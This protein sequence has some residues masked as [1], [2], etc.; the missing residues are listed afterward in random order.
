MPLTVDR[1]SVID[2]T[3]ATIRKGILGGEWK[4][5]LPGERRLSRDLSVGRNSVRVALKILESEGMVEILPKRGV[6]IMSNEARPARKRNLV[7]GMLSPSPM[8]IVY[9]RQILWID[10]LR[11]QLAKAGHILKYYSGHHYFRTG[12]DKAVQKL[13]EQES[14]DCW[15]LVAS[16]KA[17]QEWFWSNQIPCLIAG[18]CHQGIDLPFIDVDYQALSRHAVLTLRR[19]GHRNIVYLAP[20]PQLAGDI[21][22]ETGFLEGLEGVVGGN[23][24]E[25]TILNLENSVERTS[26]A[27]NRLMKQRNM[28]TALLINNPFQYLTVFSTLTEMGLQVPHDVSLICRGSEH[29]LSYL[30]PSPVRYEQNPIEFADRLFRSIRKLINNPSIKARSVLFMP[31]LVEGDS[32]SK[33][34]EQ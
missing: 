10:S 5:R 2:Q 15:V 1:I 12:P 17:V 25:G 11:D 14:C 32:I 26:F 21:Q 31:D 33:L 22:S 4:G 34:R 16:N 7:V 27:L 6:Q 20:V 24:A 30:K 8:E 23:A 29:F 28:P 18:S 19:L 9:P 3:A 13:V